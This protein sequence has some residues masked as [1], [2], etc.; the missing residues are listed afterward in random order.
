MRNGFSALSWRSGVMNSKKKSVCLN[1]SDHSPWI[2][3][4]LL[5]SCFDISDY[6]SGM[7]MDTPFKP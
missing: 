6:E 3:K 1:G 2:L 5:S 4:G 7:A